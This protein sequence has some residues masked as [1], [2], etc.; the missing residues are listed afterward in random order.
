MLSDHLCLIRGGGDLGTGVALQLKRKGMPVIVCD[1]N[2]PLA[3]RRKVAFS[4]AIIDGKIRVEEVTGIRIDD[5]SKITDF[6]TTGIVPVFISKSLPE[7]HVSVIVDARM[8]KKTTDTKIDD[9][10]LV[11]ALGPGFFAG[12]DCHAVVET[13]RGPEMGQVIWDGSAQMNTGVPGEVG[14]L[15]SERLLRSPANGKI[16]WS[17]DIGDLVEEGEV[18]GSVNGKAV[19]AGTN[20]LIRGLINEGSLLEINMKVGDIDPRGIGVDVNKISD[21]ALAVGDGVTEAVIEWL[22]KKKSN[23]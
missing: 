15:T 18:V 6:L 12:Q 21:K 22:E 3:V 16:Q 20:G 8:R 11:V 13:M 17:K 14:G 2:D 9:A 19:L 7:I 5:L 23:L 1:L 4:T 10:D